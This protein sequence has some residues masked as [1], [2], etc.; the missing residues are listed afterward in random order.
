MS[1]PNDK[2]KYLKKVIKYIKF[3]FDRKEIYEELNNHI[4]DRINELYKDGL[5]IEMA[6]NKS[7]EMMGDAKKVGLELNKMHNPFLGWIWKISDFGVKFFGVIVCLIFILNIITSIDLGNPIKDI[8]KEDIIYHLKVNE[9]AKID[10]RVI[11]IKDILYDN[12]GILHIRYITYNSNLLVNNAWN[13]SNLGDITDEF[14]KKYYGGSSSSSGIISHH[15]IQLDGFNPN[16]SKLN[17]VY[18]Q[19]NRQFE[20]HFDLQ[21]GAKYE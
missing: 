2:D 8:P 18:N 3:P 7:I 10:S 14:G 6:T 9:K 11:N 20:F 19:Y 13:F 5:S 17:I 21:E 15:Y 12:K 16:S 4:D 1:M